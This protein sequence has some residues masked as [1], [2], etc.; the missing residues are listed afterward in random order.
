MEFLYL[1]VGLVVGGGAVWFVMKAQ[2]DG[3]QTIQP[4]GIDESIFNEVSQTKVR[5][6]ERSIFLANELAETKD[7]LQTLQDENIN[8]NKRLEGSITHFKNQEERIKEQKEDLSN[9]NEKF[10]K[11][12]ENIASKLL[13]QNSEEISKINKEKLDLTLNPLKETIKLFEEK[14]DRNG[15][16]QEGLKEQIHLLHQLNKTMANEAQNLTKALKG[17]AKK[18][19]NWGEVILERILERSGLVKG[20][21]YETQYSSTNAEG[22]RVQPDVIIKLPEDKHIIIDS[23]VSLVAY[24]RLVN[25]DNDEDR[26]R[27]IK[28]HLVSVKSHIKGLS[29]KA[30]QTSQGLNTPDFVLLFIPIEASFS[31]A[32][33]ADVEL[34]NFAWDNKIVI[35]SPSTLLAT[36]RT[37]SSIWKQERQNKNALEIAKQ[38]GALYDKFEGFLLDMDKIDKGLQTTQKS[39]DAAMNK[40]HTGTGNLISRAQRIKKLGANAQKSIS[41]TLTERAEDSLSEEDEEYDNE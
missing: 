4:T 38:S 29:D 41:T 36:L 12:F 22:N 40:L 1:F 35:V 33:Q 25:A 16:D 20:Q 17:D 5:F 8:L 34:F 18:Q 9:L 2:M 19:G 15:K 13:R 30:Y 6:E 3:A 23:K 24:E 31:V 10:Q 26:D 39:Y 37:I 11:E 21:E 28:E 7:K 32:V 14:I 27:A